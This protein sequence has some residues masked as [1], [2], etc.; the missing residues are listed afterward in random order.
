V[1]VTAPEGAGTTEVQIMTKTSKATATSATKQRARKTDRK[2]AN[3]RQ[4]KRAPATTRS[5]TNAETG[6]VAAPI[7]H[8]KKAAILGLLERPDGAAISDLTALTGWQVHSVRAA[9]TGLR[10]DGKELVRVKDEAGVTRY[11]LGAV[12]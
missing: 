5:R 10:K 4:V 3:R 8:S 9:L 1:A 6:S 7:R 2:S 11:R 12:G